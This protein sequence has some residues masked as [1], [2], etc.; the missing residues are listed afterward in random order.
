MQP[1][2]N[3]QGPNVTD[4]ISMEFRCKVDKLELTVTAS[5]ALGLYLITIKESVRTA[6]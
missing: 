6:Q 4:R 1:N 3:T 2:N 5:S